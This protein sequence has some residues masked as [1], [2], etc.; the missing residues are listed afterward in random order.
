EADPE[1]VMKNM[2]ST[3]KKVAQR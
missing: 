3:K 2:T 1:T